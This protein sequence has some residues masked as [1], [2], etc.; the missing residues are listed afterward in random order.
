VRPEARDFPLHERE[1][2]DATAMDGEFMSAFVRARKGRFGW[3]EW[4]LGHASGR[5]GDRA[6]H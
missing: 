3:R 2:I 5:D 6:D 4:S 1:G